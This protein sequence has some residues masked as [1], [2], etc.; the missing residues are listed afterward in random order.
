MALDPAHDPAL[1]YVAAALAVIDMFEDGRFEDAEARFAQRLR[2]V[3]PAAAVAQNWRDEVGDRRILERGEVALKTRPDGLVTATVPL[4]L[5]DAGRLNILMS[6]DDTGQL[7]GLRFAAPEGTDWQMPDYV[8]RRRFREYEVV[9]D[10]GPA[11]VSGTMTLPHGLARIRNRRRRWGRG[12]PG[13][14]L[15]GG[16]GPFD[17]DGTAGPNKPLKDLAWGLASHGIA[18]VRF[19]KVTFTR[20]DEMNARGF[21]L[22]DEYVPHAAKAVEMLAARRGVD[23]KRIFVL[24][25]SAGGKVAPRVAEA[26]PSVAGLVILAG[27]AAPM[28]ESAVRVARHVAALNPGPEA[29]A[30]LAEFEETAASAADPEL[31]PKT[32]AD[33]L[34]FGLPAAFWL[35]LR[36]YDQVGTAAALQ[37]PM[38]F[39]QGGRDYQVT[40]EHDLALWKA[41][42]RGRQDVEFHEYR[43]DDHLFFPGSEPATPASYQVAQHVDAELIADI[44]AWIRRQEV[45][46]RAEAA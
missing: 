8:A 31:D 4:E 23:P 26:A 6:M 24:G 37:K 11:S 7:H 13:V 39:A 43:A 14:V 30:A 38:F 40:A 3:V 22:A 2:A 9:V 16:G 35:G 15:L 10:G 5:A 32:P 19:D 12:V 28:H 25:H 21:T 18:V 20:A 44:A 42:L 36:T 17:R 45:R 1:D 33:R 41:G 27:D 46:G 29:D 34:P